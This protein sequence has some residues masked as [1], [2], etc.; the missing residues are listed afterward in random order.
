M[1]LA[2]P[3]FS[4][5]S[6]LP[7]RLLSPVDPS[8]PYHWRNLFVAIQHSTCKCVPTNA[9]RAPVF[10]FRLISREIFQASHQGCSLSRMTRS[11]STMFVPKTFELGLQKYGITPPTEAELCGM[12]VVTRPAVQRNAANLQRGHK[13]LKG[14]KHRTQ[15]ILERRKKFLMREWAVADGLLAIIIPILVSHKVICWSCASHSI[16]VSSLSCNSIDCSAL[17]FCTSCC[18]YCT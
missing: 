16:V 7:H 18:T 2:H 1:Q 17:Q 4:H 6:S 14:N 12:R 11:I 15:L 5:A 10:E 9:V 3:T 8:S 13:G